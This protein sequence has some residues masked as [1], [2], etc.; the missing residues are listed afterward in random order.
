M[1][2]EMR[3]LTASEIELVAGGHRRR[4]SNGLTIG[5]ATGH[6]SVGQNGVNF[7][8]ISIGTLNL[9]FGFPG[10]SMPA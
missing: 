1:N 9:N 6:S 8:L 10:N 4:E 2:T 3:A 7:A 5:N